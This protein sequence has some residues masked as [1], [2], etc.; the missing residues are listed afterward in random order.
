MTSGVKNN[1]QTPYRSG[2]EPLRFKPGTIY[3]PKANFPAII[4]MLDQLRFA[5]Q[6]V[7]FDNVQKATRMMGWSDGTSHRWFM[8]P[9]KSAAPSLQKLDR[10]AKLAGL[11]IALVP[12]RDIPKVADLVNLYY[13]DV[14]RGDDTPVV[15]HLVPDEREPRLRRE[16]SDKLNRLQALAQRK[17]KE[18]KEQER[19]QKGR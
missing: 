11:Q 6:V 4:Q 13:Q 17:S 7:G 19:D 18:R 8:E 3:E 16:V 15:P 5:L 10:L 9:H 2:P 12:I 14:T 1:A